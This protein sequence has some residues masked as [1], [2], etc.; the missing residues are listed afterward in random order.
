[1]CVCSPRKRTLRD[2]VYLSIDRGEMGYF[3]CDFG[4]E[5]TALMTLGLPLTDEKV[6]VRQPPNRI[7]LHCQF[8]GS[9]GTVS[10]C[11]LR[12]CEAL[13]SATPPPPAGRSVHPLPKRPF[14]FPPGCH[15]SCSHVER[16]DPDSAINKPYPGYSGLYGH[17][18][19]GYT[20]FTR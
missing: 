12:S 6:V 4:G 1:M 8:S 7:T 20:T 19:H 11:P 17:G 13:C 3:E 2:N 5:T 16:H 10:R 18:T 14:R 9:P 15:T